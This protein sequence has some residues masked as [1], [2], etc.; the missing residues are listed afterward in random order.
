MIKTRDETRNHPRNPLW[1][2]RQNLQHKY[3]HTPTDIVTIIDQAMETKGHT[4]AS[5]NQVE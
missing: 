5:T 3:L 4:S 1:H 2:E